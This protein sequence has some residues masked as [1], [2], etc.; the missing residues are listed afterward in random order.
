MS[1]QSHSTETANNW[2]NWAKFNNNNKM[3][4]KNWVQSENIDTFIEGALNRLEKKVEISRLF[5]NFT[6]SKPW[7]FREIAK[8]ISQWNQWKLIDIKRV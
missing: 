2:I 6:W 3:M 5:L 7:I 4:T 8:K 1:K